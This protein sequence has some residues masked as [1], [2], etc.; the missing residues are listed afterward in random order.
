MIPVTL[1]LRNFL[2]YGE[3]VEPLDFTQLHLACLSGENGHGKSALLDAITWALWGKARAATDELVRIG[4]TEMEVDFEFLLEGSRYRVIRKRDRRARGQST[5]ELQIEVDGVAHAMTEPSLRATQAKIIELLHLDYDTFIN[6]AF[7]LQGRADE[8]TTKAPMERKQILADILGLSLYDEYESRAKEQARA[9]DIEARSLTAQIDQWDRELAQRPA[10][11]HE[12]ALA[13][14]R[15]ATSAERVHT[16]D[17][18]AQALRRELQ[19]LQGKQAQVAELQAR[20]ARLRNDLARLDKQIVASQTLIAD[21]ETILA[22]RDQIAA[23]Y[24]ALLDAR[25][26][27]EKLDV[28]LQAALKLSE[29]KAAL[30]KQ[31]EA[32]RQKWVLEQRRVADRAAELRRK[33]SDGARRANELHS[34]ADTVNHLLDLQTRRETAREG[35]A[36]LGEQ[37]ADLKARAEQLRSDVTV[38]REKRALLSASTAE[39]QCP[40]CGSPLNE[41]DQQR[42]LT[43][44]ET[45]QVDQEAAE[46][47]IHEQ[48]SAL[49][50]QAHALRT[51]ILSADKQLVNL[52]PLQT[53]KARLEA[54]L[55]EAQEAQSALAALKPEI[56]ELAS[57]LEHAD[58]GHELRAQLKEAEQEWLGVGYDA[59]AHGANREELARLAPFEAENSRLAAAGDNMRRECEHLAELMQFREGRRQDLSVAEEQVSTLGDCLMRYDACRDELSSAEKQLRQA[60]EEETRAGRVLGAA[61]QKLDA[62]GAIEA[63]RKTKVADRTAAA[64]E[65]ALFEEL[66]VAFSKRGL[67]AMIIENVLPEIEDEANAILF[68][69]TDGP[70][71]VKLDTQRETKDQGVVE[72]LDITV[73]DE[74]GARAYELFSGGEAFR[75]NFALRVALSKLLARRAGASL[76]TLVI[77]EG[78]GT[79]DAQGRERLIEAINS[80]QNDFEKVLVITHI[81]ELKE[82][83]P[84]HIEVFRT[85]SGSQVRIT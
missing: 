26:R 63:S 25:Q 33:S 11:E 61:R 52:A 31:L 29:R 74:W 30:E 9:K 47:A 73:S 67:Q 54:N 49:S 58:F 80:I 32:E 60:Q 75:I 65:K 27:Q 66:R 7:L 69:M 62:C 14:A 84:A 70:M 15:A 78:F 43:E 41:H 56:D 46:Q 12:L 8:F 3:D 50:A 13:E 42:L 4:T 85:S 81:E 79:Q 40:L 64:N 10:Y 36:H 76:Q 37:A 21:C 77:D 20:L 45:Q 23:G 5:L 17:G 57:R 55:E 48:L 19:D 83:F 35:T 28:Q 24:A 38:L 1:R 71:R 68:R 44:M 22:G 34:L 59:G 16:F 82:A 51:E 18:Q 39:A 72:T 2:C 6:S 53:R